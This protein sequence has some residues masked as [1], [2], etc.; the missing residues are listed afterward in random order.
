MR[1]RMI[2]IILVVVSTLLFLTAKNTYAQIPP[3]NTGDDPYIGTKHRYMVVAD[4]PTVNTTYWQITD[5]TNTYR[6]TDPNIDTLFTF[7]TPPTTNIIYLDVY[8]SRWVFSEGTW[9]LTYTETNTDNA[10]VATR[11]FTIHLLDPTFYESLYDIASVTPPAAY[12]ECHD[13]TNTLQSWT[14]INGTNVPTRIVFPVYMYKDEDFKLNN[15]RFDATF[16]LSETEYSIAFVN[17]QNANSNR[18]ANYTISNVSGNTWRIVVDSAVGEYGS[19]FIQLEVVLSGEMY[20]DCNVTMS[21]SNAYALSGTTNIVRT[22]DNFYVYPDEAG[23]PMDWRTRMISVNGVPAAQNIQPGAGETPWSASQPLRYSTHRY[24]VVMGNTSNTYSWSIKDALGNTVDAANYVLTSSISGGSGLSN[25]TFN[26]AEGTY[27]LIYTE[28]EGTCSTIRQYTITL[29][30]PF[31]VDIVDEPNTCA[32][33]SETISTFNTVTPTTVDYV[34]NLNTPTYAGDW[35][36]TFTTGYTGGSPGDLFLNAGDISITGII[37]SGAV[38]FVP[39]GNNYTGTVNVTYNST[40]PTTSFIIRVVYR[41]VY[42]SRFEV[43]ASMTG[44]TGSY[45]EIDLNDVL[46]TENDDTIGTESDADGNDQDNTRHY[47]W[48]MPQT[49]QLAGVD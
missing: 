22:G 20:L 42:A 47:I 41:S 44:I 25:F 26:M 49:G 9:T 23:V 24:S 43:T 30:G 2:H 8:F 34:V 39:G 15:W 29:G 27:H 48:M 5:G 31:D 1:G 12:S 36:F 4:Q 7:T 46:N 17:K 14:S 11:T 35:H 18:G 21:I 32:S 37:G 6:S 16:N 19:D 13:S 40:T 3:V 38:N 28:A 45:G 33:V 10:C